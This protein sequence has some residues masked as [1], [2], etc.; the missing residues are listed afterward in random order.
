MVVALRNSSYESS[1]RVGVG[2][3][4]SMLG[5]GFRASM[6]GRQAFGSLPVTSSSTKNNTES[7]L[8]KNQSVQSPVRKNQ[9]YTTSPWATKTSSSNQFM[10]SSSTSSFSGS[11]RE[12]PVEQQS[13]GSSNNNKKLNHPNNNNSQRKLWV[14]EYYDNGWA[15][16][17]TDRNKR[18]VKKRKVSSKEPDAIE[19]VIIK[20]S[21]LITKRTF[22]YLEVLEERHRQETSKQRISQ[23]LVNLRAASERSASL[24]EF[25][26]ERPSTSRSSSSLRHVVGDVG[27][28]LFSP[29]DL[30]AFEP[31][32][33][34][35]PDDDDDDT[36]EEELQEPP[37]EYPINMVPEPQSVLSSCPPLLTPTMLKQLVDNLPETVQ[38]M[39]WK[40][41]FALGRDGDCFLTML[42]H[43]HS[44]TNTIVVILT[45]Q[46]H[47]LGGYAAAPWDRQSGMQRTFY[48]SGQSFLFATHPDDPVAV[49]DDDG[50]NNNDDKLY[51][52]PWTGDNNYCQVCDVEDGQIAMGGGGAFGLIVQEHFSRGS[53]GR[54]GTFGNPSLIP[55][56][57]GGTFDVISFEI[58]GFSSMAEVFSPSSVAN[59]VV[60]PEKRSLLR[61]ES[62]F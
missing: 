16:T 36:V 3:G 43:C 29:L 32:K 7:P 31:L 19:R 46:G 39:T 35:I 60:T 18:H 40:R 4:A 9:S 8:R 53:T 24:Q 57:S 59:K 42:N 47:I 38:T 52:Y 30:E 13:G 21:S 5:G 26:S 1:N 10:L 37:I 62:P 6:P 50:D 28:A 48:G 25:L 15:S 22:Q 58:Y 41:L 14:G 44:Y 45:T 27:M 51:I 23:C 54:C 55:G 12:P 61:T 17:T 11:I 2:F 56:D 33:I 49:A 20:A 34:I